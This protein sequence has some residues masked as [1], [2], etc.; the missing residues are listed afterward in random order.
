MKKHKRKTYIL[1][2]RRDRFSERQWLIVLSFVIGILSGAA[3]VILKNTVHY[4]H[5]F[6]TTQFDVSRVNLLYLA[7][8]MLGIILTVLYVKFFVKDNIG[9]GVS[10]ILYAISRGRGKLKPHNTYSSMIASTLTVGF[11]GSVGLEAPI[12]LTGSAIGSNIGSFFRM[13]QRSIILLIGCGAAGAVAGIFK[14]P[15]A[16]VLF[17]LEI[18]MLDLTMTALIPLLIAA[19]TAAVL[20]YFFMGEN[21]LFSFG[22]VQPFLLNE[23]PWF[24]VLGVFTGLVSLYFTRANIK[25]ESWFSGIKEDYKKFLVGGVALSVMIFLFPPLFGEGYGALKTILAGN[26]E[27]LANNSL[28]FPLKDSFWLFLGFLGLIL[29]FKVAAMAVTTGS[30]GVGGIFAPSLFM[31][32]VSG[33]FV[34]RALNRL[35]FIDIS[36]SNFALAGMAGVMA[37]VMHAPLTAIFLIAEITGGYGLFIPLIITATTSYIVIM[38]FEPHSIYTKRL[39]KR[40]ELVTHHKDKSALAM[41]RIDKLIETNFQTINLDANLGELVKVIEQSER[42]VFPVVDEDNNFYGVVWLNYVRDIIFK[43]EKYETTMVRDLLYM[44]DVPVDINETMEEVA[45]KFQNCGH[46]NLPVLENGKYRGFVSRANVF[47]S[48]RQIIHEFSEE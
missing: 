43:P 16:G 36:E 20:D 26:G 24:I 38:Y 39:A 5:E 27:E 35:T 33:F 2:W 11:G 37:G 15:I 34:G 44:P 29:T 9:H 19:V 47:S 17:A 45:M 21:V 22:E 28:F 42:N 46:Y 10:K 1:T 23:I 4:T 3:A 41:L 7:T 6:V 40:G 14:A 48:Y 30:G 13:S 32:G 8:P 12:V 25:I 18:L 31:G